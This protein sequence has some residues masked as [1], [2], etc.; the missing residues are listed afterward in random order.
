[1]LRLMF[2][3]FMFLFVFPFVLLLFVFWIWMLIDCI[4]S[5]LKET[6]KLIWVLII[7]LANFLGALL[8]L[9]FVK[10]NES[11]K[12]FEV[13]M[14]SNKNV[15]KLYRSKNNRMLAGICGGIAEYLKIDP[16]VVRLAWI[17]LTFLGGSGILAYIICWIVIPERK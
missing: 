12:G 6:D 11:Y 8:Y 15:R 13:K 1:M 16:T 14:K 7:I 2:F 4:K 9:L 10:I 3:P 17:F 5:K